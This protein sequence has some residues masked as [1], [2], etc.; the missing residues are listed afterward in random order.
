MT[1]GRAGGWKSS[2]VAETYIE[3]SVRSKIEV[4]KKILVG[5]M[6]GI[7]SNTTSSVCPSV[8]HSEHRSVPDIHVSG[9]VNCTIQV[10]INE[11]TKDN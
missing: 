2:S 7:V 5:S 4:S 6:S 9:N 8:H 1:T 10:V 11:S 3:D